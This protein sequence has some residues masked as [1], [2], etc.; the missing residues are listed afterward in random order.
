MARMEREESA[1]T[2]VTV[3]VPE[4]LLDEFDEEVEEREE[5]R[6]EAVR[7][8]MRSE[9]ESPT[10]TDARQPP[11]D[12]DLLASAYVALRR[13]AGE[14]ALPIREAKSVI[15]QETGVPQP[16]I[17]RRILSPLRDRGYLKRTGDPVQNPYIA[18]L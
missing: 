4:R 15:A 7:R 9:I 14:R 18:V 17:G 2:R 8:L 11:A 13:Y 12:D 10:D 6:S 1:K 3:R 5:S 16:V